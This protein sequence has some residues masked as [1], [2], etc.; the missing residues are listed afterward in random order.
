MPGGGRLGRRRRGWRRR[1]VPIMRWWFLILLA[2]LL[3]CGRSH[4]LA[5]GDEY[6]S[7]E[8]LLKQG[9]V[10]QALARADTG[11]KKCGSSVEWCWKFRL[12]KAQAALLSG[13]EREALTL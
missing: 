12:L 13:Q 7:A 4:N 2:V 3:G 6:V 1:Y 11:L 8:R 5:I 10:K 9:E